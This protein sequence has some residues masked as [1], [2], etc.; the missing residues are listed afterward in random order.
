MLLTATMMVERSR[1]PS[2]DFHTTS[3]QLDGEDIKI[4]HYLSMY[5]SRLT[6]LEDKRRRDLQ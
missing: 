3:W 2:S 4:D 5:Y 6:P 1:H